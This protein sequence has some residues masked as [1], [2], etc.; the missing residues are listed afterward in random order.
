VKLGNELLWYGVDVFKKIAVK[1][2]VRPATAVPN[3][4]QQHYRNGIPY[5]STIIFLP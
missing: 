5:G 2:E 4:R 1:T 3:E